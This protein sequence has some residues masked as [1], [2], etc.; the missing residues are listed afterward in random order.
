MTTAVDAADSSRHEDVERTEILIIGAGPAGSVA[1]AMLRQQGR[2]VLMLERQQFPRFS[3]GESLLP[4]SME[5]IEAAGLLQ[6]VVE[7][8]FQYKNGAAFVHGQARTA[9]D[10]RKKFSPGWGTT[11]QVQRADFDNVLA[12]GAERMGA[13]LRFGDE[14]L[15]VEP[16]EQPLVSVRRPDGSEYRIEADFIL[17]ASGFARLLPRLLDL[18]SPSNFPVRGAIF[19]H[20]RD[21]IPAEA[22][23]DRNKILITTHPEHIDVWYWTIPFSNGCCSL[24]VVA[25][26][27]FFERY[28][29]DDLQKLQAIVGE[30]PNLTS[31]LANAEWAVLPVRRITGY[32]ANVS[33]LWGPGYALLGNAGEFLDPVFSSGV[34]IAFK[35]AQL[36]SECLKRRY[37]GETV[38]W[39]SEFSI[40]LRAGVKT[41]RRF[42]ESWYQGGF[43]KII[44]HPD[45]QPQVRDMISSILAGYAWDT[46]N[47]YVADDSGRRMR[48]LEELCSA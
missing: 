25:E 3:I 4:Q 41:F 14:V 35:S 20:V 39:E 17:D 13:T 29:G 19:C 37:A 18:E 8:G 9:F 36:A 5:Y 38:D 45:Q 48:V 23:F 28:E 15:S 34:T 46:N 21:N 47:P 16:G 7:A 22:D 30:D 12:R 31:L 24:G 2:K 44:Y 1:A 32:S 43:Q 40:P 33:S 42:V 26:P 10:F 6:D 27:S 11:Y